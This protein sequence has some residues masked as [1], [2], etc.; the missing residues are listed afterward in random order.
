MKVVSGFSKAFNYDP[1][2]SF[3][4]DQTPEHAW[5]AVYINDN[6]QFVDCTW[7]AGSRD[8]RGNFVKKFSDFHFLTEPKLFILSHFPYMDSDMSKSQAWQLLPKP[9]TLDT[10]SKRLKGFSHMYTCKI[11]PVSHPDGVITFSNKIEVTMQYP[12]SSYFFLMAR[13]FKKQSAREFDQYVLVENIDGSRIKV[14]VSPPERGTYTLKLFGRT[15][16]KVE[17]LTALA[18]YVLK[19]EEVGDHVFAFPKHQGSFGP[20]HDY[21]EAG[22]HSSVGKQAVMESKNGKLDF[23]IKTT[24]NV[25]AIAKMEHATKNLNPNDNYI[26]LEREKEQLYI[27]AKF[28]SKGYYKLSIFTKN[29]NA[30]TYSP[31]IA[32]LVFCSQD[33]PKCEPFPKVF[34]QTTQYE[35]RL[36]SPVTC[37]IKAHEQ[38]LFRFSSPNIVQ[39]LLHETPMEKKGTVWE[40]TLRTSGPGERIRVS[41][42]DQKGSKYWRIYEFNVM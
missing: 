39:A 22:F 29:E 2:T 37:E 16:P 5:N 23:L 12:K 31:R 30:D 33:D 41:A 24:K 35:C 4:T 1:E 15:D 38:I 19:C 10:F 11:K 18:N 21:V 17:E 27:K 25:E 3:T 14:K 32:Y 28:P 26:L 6:W 8:D 40:G 34:P 9:L 20:Y 7:G 36:L 13:L 42:S